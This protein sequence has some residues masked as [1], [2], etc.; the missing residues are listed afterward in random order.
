MCTTVVATALAAEN[1]QIAVSVVTG[2]FS[3]SGGS[4]GALPQP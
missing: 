2:I 3:A 1:A 4:S